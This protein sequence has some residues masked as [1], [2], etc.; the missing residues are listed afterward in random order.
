M[1]SVSIGWWDFLRQRL[2]EA[3]PPVD[4][5]ALLDLCEQP[6]PAVLALIQ[7]HDQAEMHRLGDRFGIVRIDDHRTVQLIG[8]ASEARQDQNAGIIL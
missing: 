3:L 2:D 6:A 5:V 1:P 4:D 7:R 8:G